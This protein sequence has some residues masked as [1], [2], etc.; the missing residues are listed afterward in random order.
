MDDQAVEG[1]T[2]D[3]IWACYFPVDGHWNQFGSDRFAKFENPSGL[4]SSPLRTM[5]PSVAIGT[6]S[7]SSLS[8][9]A[10]SIGEAR[11][12]M[13][14]TQLSAPLI[15]ARTTG[16][17]SMLMADRQEKIMRSRTRFRALWQSRFHHDDGR[18]CGRR[19]KIDSSRMQAVDDV[20]HGQRCGLCK[21]LAV[22]KR[23]AINITLDQ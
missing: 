22:I 15:A 7:S 4:R 19:H 2:I 17:G 12:S 5:V 16:D 18:G 8:I 21:R 3:E 23:T 11:S 6:M 20:R 14:W 1:L 9:R 10:M 13:R